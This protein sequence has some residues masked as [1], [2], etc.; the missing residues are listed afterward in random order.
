MGLVITPAVDK[1]AYQPDAFTIVIKA[2]DDNGKQCY[3]RNLSIQYNITYDGTMPDLTQMQRIYSDA[4]GIITLVIT[5]ACVISLYGIYSR[6]VQ[7]PSKGEVAQELAINYEITFQPVVLEMTATYAGAAVPLKESLNDSY[8]TV[9]AKMSDGTI[10]TIHPSEYR[11]TDYIIKKLG[12]NVKTLTYIDPILNIAWTV[13]FIVQGVKNL[14]SIHATYIGQEKFIGDR[15]LPEEVEVFG[16]FITDVDNFGQTTLNR[17]QVPST[18]WF[19]ADIPVIT[20]LNQGVIRIGLQQAETTIAVPYKI[21]TSLRLNVWY[22]GV[23]IKVGNTYS[24]DDLVIYLIDADGKRKKISWQHCSISSYL[25]EEEGYNWFTV[26]YTNE[27][28][29]I[30][31]EFPVEGIIYKDFVDLEFKVL[32]S[33]DRDSEPEDLTARF[34]QIL[35]MDGMVIIDWSNFLAAVNKI[36]RYGIYT[37][38]V[39]K[40]SGL[41]NQ[42]D[43]DWEVLCINDV[44]LKAN[45]QKI[46]NEEE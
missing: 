5:K 22:E 45:I 10:K 38:T 14:R 3:G 17:E 35:E 30:T 1:W 32:Y 4:S 12:D 11:I 40:L 37:V 31:Q 29:T 2:Y 21:T 13:K 6:D 18:D 46:Y 16:I 27:Y 33:K 7:D 42:Y 24:P 26:S 23:K 36:E 43:M 8:L 44:T 19:F 15:I 34:R 25:V 41:S 20:D 9:K 39:P 28:A